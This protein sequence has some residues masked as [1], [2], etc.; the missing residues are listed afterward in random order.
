M[1][2]CT[3][4]YIDGISL[5]DEVVAACSHQGQCDDDVKASMELPEVKAELDKIDKEQL[6]KELSEYGA[7]S[8]EELANHEDNLMRILWIAAGNISDG[9][10][11]DDEEE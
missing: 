2:Y 7:W 11:Y 1:K 8:D 9:D 6:V 5:S 4:N 3:F 10:Y